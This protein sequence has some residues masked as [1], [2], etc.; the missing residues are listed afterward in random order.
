MKLTEVCIK[1]PVIAMVFS[2]AIV[3][4]GVWSFRT[5]D[6]QYF[7]EHKKLTATVDASIDGASA[8]VHV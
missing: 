8:K 7:P 2:I 4:L 3:L 1:H 6:I 5:L